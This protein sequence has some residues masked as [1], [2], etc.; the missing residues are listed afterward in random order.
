MT[1]WCL[2]NND[3]AATSR[4]PPGAEEFR[5]SHEQVDGQEDQIAQASNVITPAVV[6]KSAQTGL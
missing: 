3:S 5:H 4:A 6:R 1:I 2:S